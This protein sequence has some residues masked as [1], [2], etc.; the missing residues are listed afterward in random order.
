MAELTKLRE[1]SWWTSCNICGYLKY[2][3]RYKIGE[4]ELNLCKSC[5]LKINKILAE[6]NYNSKLNIKWK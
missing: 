1:K 5:A 4:L 2:T 3:Y 6:V